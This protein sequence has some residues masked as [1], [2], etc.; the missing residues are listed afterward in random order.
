MKSRSWK[1]FF[2]TTVIQSRF[3]DRVVQSFN[4]SGQLTQ[5]VN[6]DNFDGNYFVKIP[7]FGPSSQIFKSKIISLFN[8]SVYLACYS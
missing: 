4:N 1:L 6:S 7:Y 3:F 8:T 5:V 2:G